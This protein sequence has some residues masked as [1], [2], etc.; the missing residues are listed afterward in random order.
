ML[1]LQS[2]LKATLEMTIKCFKTKCNLLLSNIY[3]MTLCYLLTF[4]K[5]YIN[6]FEN[7]TC[8]FLAMHISNKVGY[9]EKNRVLHEFYQSG[10][11]LISTLCNAGNTT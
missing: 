9:A 8:S 6:I 1:A 7:T 11:V 4:L 10:C 3:V 5:V 2:L